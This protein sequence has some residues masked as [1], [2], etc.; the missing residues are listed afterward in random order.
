M[1]RADLIMQRYR[2]EIGAIRG[3]RT[4]ERAVVYDLPR[5]RRFPCGSVAL[6]D[7]RSRPSSEGGRLPVILSI[8]PHP[9]S[10]NGDLLQHLLNHLSHAQPLNF[11]FRP[12]NQT[13]LQHRQ[14]ESLDIVG[15]NKVATGDCGMGP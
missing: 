3:G 2:K 10:W 7:R 8:C 9:S 14:S 15:R 6:L 13:V 12:K 5:L 11:K 4:L 1:G